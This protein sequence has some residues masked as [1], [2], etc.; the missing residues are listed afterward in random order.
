MTKLRDSIGKKFS[1]V[2]ALKTYFIGN[3]VRRSDQY[4]LF[5]LDRVG[6]G[7]VLRTQRVV[8]LRVV[9]NPPGEVWW[10]VRLC[11]Q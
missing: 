2:R 6:P 1:E 7:H 10:C 11:A 8:G 3:N 9:V 4:V 5:Q